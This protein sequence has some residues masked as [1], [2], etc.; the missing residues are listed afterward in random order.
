MDVAFLYV[1]Y[2]PCLYKRDFQHGDILNT[3]SYFLRKK[4]TEY[5]QVE[6]QSQN[7]AHR[8]HHEGEQ[9]Q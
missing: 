4:K 5:F 8:W 9:I 6:P 3:F 1:I 7:I 2:A